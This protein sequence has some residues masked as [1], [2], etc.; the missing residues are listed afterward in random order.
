MLGLAADGI[1]RI[2]AK[3]GEGV[4]E[5][6]DAIVDRIPAPTG[7]PAAPLQALIFDSAYDQYRGV[8]SSLRVMEGTL[9]ATDRLTFMHAATNHDVEEIGI[10]APATLPVEVLGPGEV[11]YLIAGIKDVGGARS[12]ETVT[13][14]RRS[15]GFAL[16]RVSRPEAHGLLWPVP[17]RRGRAARPAGRPREAAA[18]RCQLHL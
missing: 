1:L 17:H 8:V 6:L 18:Q 9:A 5:L 12:G 7:D 3:T 13:T 10:R 11:G 2:S 15:G 4:P 16:G 14:A